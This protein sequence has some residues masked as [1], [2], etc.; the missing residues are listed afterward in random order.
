MY[1]RRTL[2]SSMTLAY[3]LLAS[4]KK[5]NMSVKYYK[6]F[7]EHISKIDELFIDQF[8]ENGIKKFEDKVF[9]GEYDDKYGK[10][11]EDDRTFLI[12][13]IYLCLKSE[14]EETDLK[15]KYYWLLYTMNRI[16][17]F[18]ICDEPYYHVQ[19]PK[20]SEAQKL[21]YQSLFE[22]DFLPMP[23]SIPFTI[24]YKLQVN[25]LINDNWISEELDACFIAFKRFTEEKKR[26][27]IILE[28][29]RPTIDK[30]AFAY[31]KINDFESSKQVIE[32]VTDKLFE[33]YDIE[34]EKFDDSYQDSIHDHNKM[35]VEMLK[36]YKN[37]EDIDEDHTGIQTIYECTA[38]LPEI[39]LEFFNGGY[40]RYAKQILE[41]SF[42]ALYYM[43]KGVDED[44]EQEVLAQTVNIA[45]VASQ[46][47]YIEMLNPLIKLIDKL[48]PIVPSDTSAYTMI[49][50]SIIMLY[51]DANRIDK[52]EA[53]V[54][55]PSKDIFSTKDFSDFIIYAN[56]YHGYNYVL[57]NDKD[58]G[59]RA[60]DGALKQ[61]YN[62]LDK[63]DQKN[64]FTIEAFSIAAS[65]Y[66]HEIEHI[67][68][69]TIFKKFIYGGVKEG[70]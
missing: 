36:I 14:L 25:C 51:S 49:F 32:Y 60:I 64:N 56:L 11:D 68:L 7:Q 4:I 58:K 29:G 35:T 12:I 33:L 6:E 17:H 47:G 16:S 42:K 57:N 59:K 44:W 53:T 67:Y 24:A 21:M 62:K 45:H 30:L 55:G 15:D 43:I 40:E 2:L 23:I 52:I 10:N 63:K 70:L 46:T 34:L 61:C 1:D 27:N 50:E 65:I 18:N 41:Q 48:A 9:D 69:D 28:D 3:R 66:N 38:F 26:L 13:M 20:E 19:I 5:S 39:A 8:G 54:K 31:S 22:E 37:H